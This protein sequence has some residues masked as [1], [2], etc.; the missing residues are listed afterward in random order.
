MQILIRE[1]T[2]GS[3]GRT[4][5]RDRDFDGDALTIG[6]A[7][8]QSIQVIGH[9][10]GGHHAS[11]SKSRDGL[12]L[13]CERGAKVQVDDQAEVSKAKLG[14]GATIDIAGNKLTLIDPPA[15]FD[16]ALTVELNTDV[17]ASDFEAAF[18]TDLEQT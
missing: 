2:T 3:D 7:P 13:R 4:E 1:I 17:E 12:S 11:L 10:I 8:D 14:V 9:G 6:S 5:F 18:V 15:G 16:A